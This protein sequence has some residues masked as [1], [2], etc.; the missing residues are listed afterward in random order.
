MHALS[1]RQ[2]WLY[3]I[4]DLPASSAKR[5]EN[6]TW[7]P[8]TAVWG[9][10]IALHASGKMDSAAGCI[11]ASSMAEVRLSRYADEMPLGAVVATAVVAG[12]MAFDK[13]VPLRY[14]R[15]SKVGSTDVNGRRV[16]VAIAPDYLSALSRAEQAC[17]ARWFVG[18]VGWILADV[19]KLPEPVTASGKLGLWGWRQ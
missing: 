3:C 12:V 9:Q 18:P 11:A 13:A 4:T 1:I 16:Y 19:E 14:V 6:R 8:P 2:P 17:H 10:R 5:V 7:S 15:D